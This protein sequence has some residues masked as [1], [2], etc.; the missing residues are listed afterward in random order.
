ML[1]NKGVIKWNAI[2]FAIF[3]LFSLIFGLTGLGAMAIIFAG[4][5]IFISLIYF[6]SKQ[7]DK[8]KACLLVGGSLLLVG[9]ALCSAF[10]LNFH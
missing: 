1:F 2:F 10:P 5:N 7:N 3:G 9:F 6:L 8:A 4:V